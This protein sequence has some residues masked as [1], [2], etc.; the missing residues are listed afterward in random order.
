MFRAILIGLGLLAA[1]AC[2]TPAQNYVAPS[3][4]FSRP[5]LD[6]IVTVGVGEAMLS[7][8]NIVYLDGVNVAPSTS[9]SGYTFQGG[10]YPQ[11]GQDENWTYHSYAYMSGGN[12]NLGVLSKNFLMDPPQSIRAS[13]EN[14]RLCVITVFNVATCSNRDFDREQRA[15]ASSNAFQQTLLYSGRI[16]DAISISYREFSGNVARPAFSN[17]VQYDLSISSEI[18][19]RGAVIEVISATNTEITYRVIRNFN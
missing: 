19:Y 11:T 7:Q 16:G 10:F 14:D 2:A 17:D 4:Q 8:G 6:T 3:E 13:H 12:E 9:V 18:G 1:S 15:I 5:E